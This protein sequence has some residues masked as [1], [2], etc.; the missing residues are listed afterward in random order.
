MTI[1]NQ[2]I[3]TF[4]GT[5]PRPAT[6]LFDGQ[7]YNGNQFAEALHQFCPYTRMIVCVTEDARQKSWPFI[8]ALNDPRIKAL[9]IPTAATPQDMWQIFDLITE[10]INEAENVV[11]DIT[12]AFR[13][14]PFLVFL[15]SAYLKAAKKVRIN[16]IY[17]GA[18][19]LGNP[20][21]VQDLSEFVSMI[22]WITATDRFVQSGNGDA[23]GKMLRNFVPPGPIMRND[24][25]QRALGSA[26]KELSSVIEDTSASLAITHPLETMAHA[27][28]LKRRL[29]EAQNS[30]AILAR[31]FA[32]LSNQIQETYSPFALPEAK[33]ASNSFNNLSIQYQM[34]EWYIQKGQFVQA[35]T[36]SREWLVSATQYICHKN[37]LF[38]RSQRDAAENT[39]NNAVEQK[40]PT[41]R[42]PLTPNFDPDFFILP[43]KTLLLRAWEK[44]TDLR[45]D[46]AHCGMDTEKT[47]NAKKV[48]HEIIELKELLQQIS[49]I[50]TP[51]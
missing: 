12:H 33:L 1:T 25:T 34:I 11:F 19:E 16:A 6:Y 26:L 18:F 31:P 44:V 13:S 45:N 5:S 37:D 46:L 21:P 4:L 15:F 22:D 9:N 32:V 50:L 48:A 35:A 14:L 20:A 28:N 2:T 41:P 43:N 23:L 29:A 27:A 3:I 7:V 30:I 17:Y 42:K 47:K 8:E 24:L 10:Q 49:S 39:L 38:N 36:L 40:K 51:L